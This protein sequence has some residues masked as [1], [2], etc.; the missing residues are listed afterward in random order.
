[1][2][3]II[4]FFVHHF[5]QT[6]IRDLDFATHVSLGEKDVARLQVIVNDWRFDFIQI[7]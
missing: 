7:L 2:I 6:E 4:I 3:G 1:M 5:G